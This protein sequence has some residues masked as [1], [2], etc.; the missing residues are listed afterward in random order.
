MH[1][2]NTIQ[3]HAFAKALEFLQSRT[4]HHSLVCFLI[5]FSLCNQVWGREPWVF[6]H[7]WSRSGSGAVWEAPILHKRVTSDTVFSLEPGHALLTASTLPNNLPPP[8]SPSLLPTPSF[9]CLLLLPWFTFSANFDPFFVKW[10]SLALFTGSAWLRK[11]DWERKTRTWRPGR[12]P[13][14][15]TYRFIF[16]IFTFAY[17]LFFW[18]I[19]LLI[20]TMLLVSSFSLLTSNPLTKIL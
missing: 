15:S 10:L 1:W 19:T 9:L 14:S 3:W 11:A 7:S 17:S 5:L 18:C 4:V 20:S 2:F 8:L 12:Y 16:M 13:Q 6:S